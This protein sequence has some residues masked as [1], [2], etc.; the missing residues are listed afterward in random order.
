MTYTIGSVLR[1]P[2]FPVNHYGIYIGKNQVI[3]NS[4]TGNGV[5]IRSL[6]E[7]SGNNHI[8]VHESP[9]TLDIGAERVKRASSFLGTP[10]RLLSQ[11]C[12]HFYTEIINGKPKSP[13]V[14]VFTGMALLFMS[15]RR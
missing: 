11:N 9:L 6:Q 13:Q 8:H 5:S 3:D 4:P 2:K 12:E 7:F 10:Y 15:L 14:I 1:T